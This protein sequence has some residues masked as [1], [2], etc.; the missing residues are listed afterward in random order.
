LIFKKLKEHGSTE[1]KGKTIK[2]E[3]I[4]KIEKGKKIAYS[5]DTMPNN[6]MIKLAENAELLIHD[7]TFFDEPD[8]R[9][10]ANLEEVMK[11]AEEAN[12][13]QII[14]THISRRYQDIEEMKKKI[15]KYSHVKIA[16]DFMKVVL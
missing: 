1:Y 9:K 10:H 7:A 16:K 5:G 8:A 13:K 15:E 4:A 3:E 6:N 14:L 11:I 12:A 2:L